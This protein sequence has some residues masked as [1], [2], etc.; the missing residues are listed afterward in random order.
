MCP[1]CGIGL[2]DAPDGPQCWKCGGRVGVKELPTAWSPHLVPCPACRQEL[3]LHAGQDLVCPNCSHVAFG[4]AEAALAT[5]EPENLR[6][7]DC[8]G[9]VIRVDGTF[10][11]AVAAKTE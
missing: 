10:Y 9:R 8:G 11:C 5:V 7:R 4:E 3:M 1:R 6:C 2:R